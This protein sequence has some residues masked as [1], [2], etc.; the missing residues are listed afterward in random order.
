MRTALTNA[1]VIIILALSIALNMWLF[2]KMRDIQR[3]PEVI[4]TQ[5][6][7]TVHHLREIITRTLPAPDPILIEQVDT[8]YLRD[9]LQLSSD[10]LAYR[11][12]YQD[13]IMQDGAVIHYSHS[14]VGALESSLYR[15]VIPERTIT[16]TTE[17]ATVRGPRYKLYPVI[18]VEFSPERADLRAG[19]IMLYDDYSLSYTYGM[20]NR[21]HNIMFGVKLWQR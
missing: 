20:L 10:S 4:I 1:T 9:T 2:H 17:T 6:T 13:S 19:G 15:L 21:S 12:V 16:N 18:G 8:L 5:R 11:R 14:V 7:D 3:P